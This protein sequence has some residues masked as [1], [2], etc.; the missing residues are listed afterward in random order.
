MNYGFSSGLQYLGVSMNGQWET[1]GRYEAADIDNI[2][3]I[4]N[5]GPVCSVNADC[6]DG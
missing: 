1:S 2:G 5:F 6:D 3:F 4:S